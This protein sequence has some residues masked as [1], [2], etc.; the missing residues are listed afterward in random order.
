VTRDQDL[1]A[2]KKL[3]E[4]MPALQR[5]LAS[6]WLGPVR[7]PLLFLL[8]RSGQPASSKRLQRRPSLLPTG[9]RRPVRQQHF[10]SPIPRRPREQTHGGW[11]FPDQS[12][13]SCPAARRLS[14][15]CGLWPRPRLAGC[16]P[17]RI[18]E[19]VSAALFFF[20]VPRL[21]TSCE[22]R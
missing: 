22:G 2:G 5:A 18:R 10:A 11:A 1:A 9:R 17:A 15:P 20:F 7:L 4:K 13:R 21:L 3:V 14:F 8:Q 16:R 6:F 12:P 19:E